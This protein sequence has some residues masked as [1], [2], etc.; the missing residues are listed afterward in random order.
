MTQID[1]HFVDQFNQELF[2]AFQNKGGMARPRSFVKSG[3]IGSTTKFPKMGIAGPA[4][5]KTRNGRVP[6]LDVA[7]TRVTCTLVDRYGADMIDKLDELKTNVSEKTTVQDAIVMS[8][9]RS[10]D[11]DVYAQLV[12]GTNAGDSVGAGDTWTSDA[13][14][15][16]VLQQFGNAEMMENGNN[17]ASISWSAWNALLSLNSFINS[18]YGGD[19]SL[20]SEGQSPKMYFG[21]AYSPYS[22]QPLHT[23]GDYLNLWWNKRCIGTAVGQD[24]QAETDWLPEYHAFQVKG[25]MSQGAVLI[26]TTGVIKRRH[27]I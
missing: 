2:V 18:Q 24:I 17:F 6:L 16:L 23:S 8:L 11:D 5:Q 4:Q 15:R 14:P 13:I 7:R 9:N 27:T 1:V 20:T 12:Q 3:V 22:R 19:T 10:Q 26:E 25:T 21:F